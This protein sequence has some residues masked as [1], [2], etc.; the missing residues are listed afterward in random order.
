MRFFA[1]VDFDFVRLRRVAFAV[2]AGLFLV[3]LVSFLGRGGLRM[4]IDFEG[5]NLV[6]IRFDEPVPLEHIRGVLAGAGLSGSEVQNFGDANE[7]LI[8]TKQVGAE[9][10]GDLIRGALRDDLPGNRASL[11]G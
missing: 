1:Q 10:V 5:G 3:G 6:Q 7:V 9:K 8:R 11:Y 2:S 4:S